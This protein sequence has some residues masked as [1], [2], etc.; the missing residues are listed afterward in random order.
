LLKSGIVRVI[1]FV[2]GAFLLWKFQKTHFGNATFI[3]YVVVLIGEL[4]V[5]DHVRSGWKSKA[6]SVAQPPPTTLPR[7]S[8]APP[9]WTSTTAATPYRVAQALRS[10]AT[11][12][13]LMVVCDLAIG[14]DWF[15]TQD[16]VDDVTILRVLASLL[17]WAIMI[18]GPLF[19]VVSLA[20]LLAER[21]E[22][23]F[24][25]ANG[26]PSSGSGLLGAICGGVLGV[27][28]WGHFVVLYLSVVRSR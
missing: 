17:A 1:T 21:F 22:R 13:V 16:N 12:T 7:A 2:V 14:L 3:G 28:T 25:D 4:L 10:V 20:V 15:K 6:G 18:L 23:R 27:S 11:V 24:V 19:N 8:S 9:A 26:V 5:G